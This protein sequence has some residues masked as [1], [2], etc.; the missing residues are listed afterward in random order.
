MGKEK[1]HLFVIEQEK[2]IIDDINA[3]TTKTFDY[4]NGPCSFVFAPQGSFTC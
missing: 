2:I 3:N 1:T 4:Q